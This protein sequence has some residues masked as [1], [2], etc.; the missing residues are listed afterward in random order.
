MATR[1][2][3]LGGPS[4]L[5]LALI[6][7]ATRK[8]TRHELEALTER[9]IEELDRQ[10]GDADAEDACD[11]EDDWALSP[12]TARWF[13]D[14]GPGCSISDPDYSVDDLPC[15]AIDEDAGSYEEGLIKPVY[16]IDQRE[17]RTYFGTFS[18][19]REDF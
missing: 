16:G 3:T 8:L 5:P 6:A 19:L 17:V 11:L 1:A 7:Q 18:R 2:I 15:D 12:V 14:R 10:D 13:L 9:L 4:G